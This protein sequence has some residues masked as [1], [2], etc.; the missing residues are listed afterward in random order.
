MDS[1]WMVYGLMGGAEAPGPFLRGVLSKR[2]RIQGTTLRARSLDYK[3]GV[4]VATSITVPSSRTAP[5]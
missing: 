4:A 5:W 1:R 2:I 3:V